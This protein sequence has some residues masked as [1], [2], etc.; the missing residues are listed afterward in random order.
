MKALETANITA[1][2]NTPSAQRQVSQQDLQ[3]VLNDSQQ[4][5]QV[6]AVGTVLNTSLSFTQGPVVVGFFVL[7]M[8]FN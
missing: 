4:L 2:L 5:S 8:F 6:V 3:A 1:P 7:L